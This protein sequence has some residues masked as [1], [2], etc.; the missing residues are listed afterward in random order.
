MQLKGY[1]KFRLNVHFGISLLTQSAPAR[2]VSAIRKQKYLELING[3]RSISEALSH[4]THPVKPPSGNN[5]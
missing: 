2:T 5:A 4:S 3:F 1:G